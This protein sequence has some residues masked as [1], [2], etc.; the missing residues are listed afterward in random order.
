MT[1]SINNQSVVIK[2]KEA[3]ADC[4]YDEIHIPFPSGTRNPVY[5]EIYKEVQYIICM[6]RTYSYIITF[7]ALIG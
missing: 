6:L 7:L 2:S 3:E 1:Y 4:G 5:S